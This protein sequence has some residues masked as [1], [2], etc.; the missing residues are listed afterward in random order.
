MKSGNEDGWYFG[1]GWQAVDQPPRNGAQREV[2]AV[3]SD[4]IEEQGGTQI[5]RSQEEGCE[6]RTMVVERREPVDSD[7]AMSSTSEIQAPTDRCQ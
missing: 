7:I 1:W 4:C 6:R 2:R 5:G 3:K